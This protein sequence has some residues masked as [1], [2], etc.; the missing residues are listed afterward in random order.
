MKLGIVLIIW[1]LSL[2]GTPASREY[3]IIALLCCAVFIILGV[4]RIKR[5]REK[6]GGSK[7]VIIPSEK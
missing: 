7:D 5:K 3:P 2:L 6:R 4:Y 1:G